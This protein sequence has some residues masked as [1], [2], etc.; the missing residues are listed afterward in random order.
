MITT[1][2]LSRLA[3]ITP[4]PE[5]PSED[6][7]PRDD[8]CPMAAFADLQMTSWY[9]DGVHWALENSVMNGVGSGR[10]EPDTP[11]SRA[12]IV[13]ML[14][15]IEGEPTSD[16][17]ITFEDVPED[18]WYTEAIRWAVAERI[19]NGYS[20]E[21]FGPNND[22]TREQLAAILCRY[23]QYKGMD[24]GAGEAAPLTGFAD[25]AQ[26]SDW[27]VP[28]VCWAVDAGI[29]NGVDRDKLSPGTDASRAQ[30]ATMLMRF[31]QM[32]Q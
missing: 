28:S 3:V 14:H 12:M 20:D 9:H 32:D 1:P 10:F 8:I 24:T 16:L 7:C 25:V 2:V 21:V 18:Q 15:R 19:V 26:V 23:A 30:V 11:T 13:T 17:A 4:E 6:G 31:L 29:I 27:A 5:A 22:L